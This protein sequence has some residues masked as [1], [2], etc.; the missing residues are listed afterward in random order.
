MRLLLAVLPLLAACSLQVP[1]GSPPSASGRVL[2]VGEGMVLGD[3]YQ[4]Q[5]VDVAADSRCP[6]GVACV[7]EGEALVVVGPSH[8]LMR[9]R[10]DTLRL[11]GTRPDSLAVGPFVVTATRLDPY[12]TST[13][14]V[15]KARYRATFTVRRTG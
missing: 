12:P 1:A 9:F 4:L 14:P 3:D 5:F 6:A 7:W 2:A 15:A 8:P 11:R 10:P 13:A